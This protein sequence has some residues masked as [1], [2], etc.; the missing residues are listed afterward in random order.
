MVDRLTG[1]GGQE[2]NQSTESNPKQESAL[3][4]HL[5]RLGIFGEAKK[6]TTEFDDDDESDKPK[7]KFRKFFKGLFKN[8]VEPPESQEADNQRHPSLESLFFGWEEPESKK[9]AETPID[10]DV[11]TSKQALKA[12]GQAIEPSLQEDVESPPS[13]IEAR[14]ETQNNSEEADMEDARV[15]AHKT[16][17]VGSRAEPEQIYSVNPTISERTAETPAEKE[18]I[19]ERGGVGA[20]LPM[21]LVGAEYLA[22]RRADRKLDAKIIEKSETLKKEVKSGDIARQQLDTLV[23]QN[24]EQLEKLKRERLPIIEKAVASKPEKVRHAPHHELP[25]PVRQEARTEAPAEARGPVRTEQ[26]KIMEQVANAA[27]HDVPVEKAFE[28]SHEVKDDVSM[29]VMAAASVGAIM[30]SKL[31][32]QRRTQHVQAGGHQANNVSSGGLPVINESVSGDMYQQAM[33]RGFWAA[34]AIIVLGMIAYLV[35]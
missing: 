25:T 9:L 21:V 35:K 4:K 15:E 14:N 12:P 28:R 32:D 5:R 11:L 18:I 19:I 17:I 3:Q 33:K 2:E 30:A 34:I 31:E 27:E 29:P 7:K 16:P 6:E 13:S 20:A 24:E 1:P 22:R 10:D 26:Y 8:V 23:K